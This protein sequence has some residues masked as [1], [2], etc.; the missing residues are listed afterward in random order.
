[1]QKI[2][3]NQHVAIFQS[4][5]KD[6]NLATHT[7]DALQN[8][9]RNRQKL[10]FL[11]HPIFWLNQTH[12]N[13]VTSTLDFSMDSDAIVS[14]EPNKVLAILTAD[15]LPILLY[16]QHAIAAIHAGWRGLASGIVENT[17][18]KIKACGLNQKHIENLNVWLGPAIGE[19]CFEVKDDVENAFSTQEQ[20]FFKKSTL[21]QEKFCGNLKKIA[22][23][24]LEKAG[25]LSKNIQNFDVC[26]TCNADF[27]SHRRDKT[28]GRMAS[29]ILLQKGN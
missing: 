2:L 16:S 9:L 12:S 17:L 11:N 15:C 19:C 20:V 28:I 18:N 13:R 14:F 7:G 21:E 29:F 3:E 22:I 23:F 27:F 1:M 6:G 25:I 10:T 8:V 5:C 4:S 24:K 26:T